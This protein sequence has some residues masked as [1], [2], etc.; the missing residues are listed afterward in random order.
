MKY[1]EITLIYTSPAHPPDGI[2]MDKA[3]RLLKKDGKFYFTDGTTEFE[4]EED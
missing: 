3:Y 1:S 4:G 2:V